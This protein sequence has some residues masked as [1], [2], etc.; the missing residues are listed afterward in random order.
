MN[1]NRLG[2]GRV[3]WVF[4]KTYEKWICGFFVRPAT[5]DNPLATYHGHLISDSRPALLPSSSR[6]TGKGR[7]RVI[8]LD[9]DRII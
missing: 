7:V 6:A 9:E 5:R 2:A 3:D 4:G 8:T 1:S